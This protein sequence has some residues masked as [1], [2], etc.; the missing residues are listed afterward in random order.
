M[1]AR[2]GQGVT[3]S[4]LE[5]LAAAYRRAEERRQEARTRLRKGVEEARER[6]TITDIADALGWTRQSVYTLLEDK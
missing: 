2:A 1:A 4:E 5:R 3:R 6:M